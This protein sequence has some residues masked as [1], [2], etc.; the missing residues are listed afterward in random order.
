[1]NTYYTASPK[2]IIATTNATL[3]HWSRVFRVISYAKTKIKLPK[4]NGF[5]LPFAQGKMCGERAIG[6]ASPQAAEARNDCLPTTEEKKKG[7]MK[8]KYMKDYGKVAF[9]NEAFRSRWLVLCRK[10]IKEGLKKMGRVLVKERL[11]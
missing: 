3:Q 9:I 7:V 10:F 4:P 8:D 5:V 2:I 1:M 11:I 6:V